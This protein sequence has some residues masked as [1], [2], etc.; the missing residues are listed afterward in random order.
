MKNSSSTINQFIVRENR[1]KYKRE[2]ISFLSHISHG[3]R[4]PLNSIMGFSKL[5]VLKDLVNP[6]QKEYIDGILNGS[7]LLLQFVDNIMDLSQFESDNYSLRMK[8][9]DINKLLWDFTEDLYNQR[10]ENNITDINLMLVWENKVDYCDIETDEVLL[11][12]ALGRMINL[13]SAKYPI[14]EFELGYRISE[15]SRI[16]LFVRPA[17]EKLK[18]ED[19]LNTQQL[20]SVDES[21]SF[22]YFN[23]KVLKHSVSL[24]GGELVMDA[25]NQEFSFEIPIHCKKNKTLI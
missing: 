16:N 11:K 5:L 22:D 3:I 19:L 13:V 1:K 14:V 10:I 21:D 9:Y 15:K 2:K 20:Y 7:N 25:N 24:L 18:S 4:T 6:K 12:K 8:K 17:R 23:F